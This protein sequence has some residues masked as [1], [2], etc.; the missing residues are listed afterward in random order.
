MFKKVLS[1]F[2]LFVFLLVPTAAQM[3]DAN[4]AVI[5]Y[6]GPNIYTALEVSM[7]NTLASYGYIDAM[8]I[9][10]SVIESTENF[11][12]GE[13]V[14][15]DMLAAEI[16]GEGFSLHT[17]KV[18]N[19]DLSLANLIVEQALEADPDVVVAVSAPLAQIVLNNT[20]NMSDPPAVLF[21]AAFNPYESG[22]A[23]SSCV[24]DDNVTGIYAVN[25]YDE[26]LS[27]VVTQNPDIQTIG[28]LYNSSVMSGVYGVAAIQEAAVGLG[29]SVEASA[30][31][32]TADLLLAAEG[33]ISR[34]AEAIIMPDDLVSR[35]GLQAVTS[36]TVEAQIPIF[37]ASPDA[38]WFG[39]TFGT[40]FG[41]YYVHGDI[42]GV[43]LASYLNGDLDIATT[44]ITQQ[45]SGINSLS[46]NTEVAALQGIEV[47]AELLSIADTI[48]S[49]AG[50]QVVSEAA[51]AIV[52]QLLNVPSMEERMEAD[53]ALLASMAC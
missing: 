46:I 30:V 3:D 1:L 7:L 4:V 31:T 13:R 38:V 28:A 8:D 37:Y 11:T 12:E 35:S 43:M 2:V 22:L 51:A 17:H 25:L 23:E 36:A 19:Y 27:L 16:S 48:T 24:K 5:S 49:E 41:E 15:G 26:I 47:A 53:A 32:S 52:Q 44:G 14:A 34:G 33:L 29:L 21:V 42:I 45:G 39:A 9:L 50:Q 10:G 18:P 40:G 6:E 20:Q